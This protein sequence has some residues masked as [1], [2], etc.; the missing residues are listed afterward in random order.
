MATLVNENDENNEVINIEITEDGDN[1]IRVNLDNLKEQIDV[2]EILAQDILER[3]SSMLANLM[4]SSGLPMEWQQAFADVYMYA[5]ALK[6]K[7][8]GEV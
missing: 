3:Y 6:V 8:E 7:Y 5:L 2:D 4:V 1:I